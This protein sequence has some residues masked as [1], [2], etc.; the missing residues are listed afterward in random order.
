MLDHAGYIEAV[1]A[2]CDADELP[3]TAVRAET[4]EGLRTARLELEVPEDAAA[5][6]TDLAGLTL[7]WDEHTGWALE[8]TYPPSAGIAP[9]P[10]TRG[11]DVAPTPE[12]VA[13]W[14]GTVLTA[15]DVL[16]SRP[17]PEPP[18]QLDDEL[19]RYQ[20]ASA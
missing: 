6:F 12:V 5:S 4:T 1:R 15:P 14:A 10:V 17:A 11:L 7:T 18:A 16:A 20:T 8:L 3:V 2:A 13:A 9:P 19:A